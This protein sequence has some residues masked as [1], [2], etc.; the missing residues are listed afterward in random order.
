[1][2]TTVLSIFVMSNIFLVISTDLLPTFVKLPVFLICSDRL[3]VSHTDYNARRCRHLVTLPSPSRWES[4]VDNTRVEGC[5]LILDILLS[6]SLL[7][8][9]YYDPPVMY[10]IFS[11]TNLSQFE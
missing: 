9:W 11:S 3:T 8:H 4:T 5:Q 7:S 10:R 2:L 6:Y 1:M